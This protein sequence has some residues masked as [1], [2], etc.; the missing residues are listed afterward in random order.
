[1]IACVTALFLGWGAAESWVLPAAGIRDMDEAAA[2]DGLERVM[3]SI[4]RAN[5]PGLDRGDLVSG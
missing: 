4:L 1:V 5:V 3:L 2:I